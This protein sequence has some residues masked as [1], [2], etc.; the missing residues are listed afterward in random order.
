MLRHQLLVVTIILTTIV[1]TSSVGSVSIQGLFNG[2][3]GDG[4]EVRD[5]SADG[6][7]IAG[8][9]R[10]YPEGGFRWKNGTVTWLSSFFEE[11]CSP[12][13]LSA[14]GTVIAGHLRDDSYIEEAFRM[15]DETSIGLGA[16][17][18]GDESW[19][20]GISADG[21][22]VVGRGPSTLWVEAF[23]WENGT[24]TGL[25]SLTDGE[26]S[27]GYDVSADG[28][29]VVGKS[30]SAL[31]QEAFRWTEAEG[32]V[33]L[34]DLPGRHYS[35]YAYG[36]SFDGSVIVGG[37]S[38]TLGS[39]AFRWTETEGMVGLGDLSWNDGSDH[40]D[41]TAYDVSAD[42]SVVVGISSNAAFLWTEQDGMRD[43]KELLEV[44]YGLDMTGWTLTAAMAISDN[45]LTIPGNGYGPDSQGGWIVTV[46]EPA[47]IL[48]FVFGGLILRKK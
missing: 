32:M 11:E 39:Q 42:G 8:R 6:S 36:V 35:S 48:L 47:T 13:A 41:S 7:V 16:L 30:D 10:S 17:P 40:T 19:A 44:D 26:W 34:G 28:K 5:I 2:P 3:D 25:G 37:S 1:H 33:G 43:L 21:S 29:V 22:V 9:H 24:M 31:G 45:G 27:E 23:R 14:D 46:P 4:V 20:R 18:G 38:S 12:W 15:E